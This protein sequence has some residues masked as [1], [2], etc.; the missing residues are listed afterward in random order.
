[1]ADD[2]VLSPPPSTPARSWRERLG[3]DAERRLPPRF[4]GVLGAVGG[5]LAAEGVLALMGQLPDEGIRAS[6]AAVALLLIVGGYLLLHAAVAPATRAAGVVLVAA[7]IGPLTFFVAVDPDSTFGTGQVKTMLV[8]AAGG[9]LLAYLVGAARGH[10]LLLGLAL[11]SSWLF[12]VSFENP[13]GLFIPV[14]P[15]VSVGAGVAESGPHWSGSGSAGALSLLVA[16]AYFLVALALDRRRLAAPATAFVAVGH[17]ALLSGMIAVAFDAGVTGTA[18]LGF[19]LAVGVAGLGVTT[20][21]RFT[22]W[23][24][25][26]G[27][28]AAAV[29]LVAE[30]VG[31]DEVAASLL[32]LVVGATVVLIA[33]LLGPVVG[34]EERPAS[35]LVDETG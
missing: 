5:V 14:A 31:D 13:A 33:Y 22:A 10:V 12:V 8:L 3:P 24:G 26:A 34:D 4:T 23:L 35:Q 20:G 9:W 29:A 17:L 32:L 19:V 16:A 11:L 30:A 28:G 21:R 18:V 27:V 1:M 6:G 15:F 2:P 7:G 25:A